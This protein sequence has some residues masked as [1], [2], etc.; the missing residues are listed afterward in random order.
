VHTHPIEMEGACQAWAGAWRSDLGLL[1]LSVHACDWGGLA[2]QFID[3]TTWE[4]AYQHPIPPK[5]L[6]GVAFAQEGT[7]AAMFSGHNQGPRS[8]LIDT[9]DWS[10][11]RELPYAYGVGG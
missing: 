7:L 3:T 9:A 10:I 5:D 8:W 6:G 2:F 4:V 11:V 1:G